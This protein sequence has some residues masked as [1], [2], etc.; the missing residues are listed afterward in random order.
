M[1]YAED[2]VFNDPHTA[3][4]LLTYLTKGY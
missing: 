1:E 2:L 4:E 3:I